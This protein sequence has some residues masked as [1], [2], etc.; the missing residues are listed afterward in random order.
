MLKAPIPN[1]EKER[2][3]AVH[4]MAILDTNPEERFD[5]LTLEAADKLRVPMSM[6]SI[7]DSEREWFKSC[8]GLDQSSG[9]RDI[10]F[11]G[12]ALLSR[13]TLIV[14]DTSLDSRFY[15]NPMVINFPFI[16]FYAGVVLFDIKTNLPIGVFCIKDTKPRSLSQDEIATL[17][18]IAHRAER[19]LNRKIEQ[20][21]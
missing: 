1:N 6:I 13:G 4:R 3:E 17:T 15:D 5:R 16:R 7:L 21:I 2:L 11:C 8:F 10:S 18:D 12:H 19:E 20:S 14:N 9:D